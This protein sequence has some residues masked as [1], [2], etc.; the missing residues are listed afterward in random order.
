M[1]RRSANAGPGS[2]GLCLLTGSSMLPN[3]LQPGTGDI[4]FAYEGACSLVTDVRRDGDVDADMLP[5]SMMSS[6]A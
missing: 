4:R 2:E 6:A 3:P 5:T 1:V